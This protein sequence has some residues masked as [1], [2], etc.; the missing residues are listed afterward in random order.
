MDRPFVICPACHWIYQYDMQTHEP[1]D[2][3]NCDYSV[4]FVDQEKYDSPIHH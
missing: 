4:Y 2:C 3:P 1:D